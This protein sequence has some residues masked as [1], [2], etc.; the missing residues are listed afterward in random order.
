MATNEDYIDPLDDEENDDTESGESGSEN[1]EETQKTD[2]VKVAED[3]SVDVSDSGE[4][5]EDRKKI[6]EARRQERHDRKTRS[7]EKDDRLRRELSSEREAR[8]ELENR[9]AVIERKS[10]GSELAQLDGTIKQTQNAYAYHKQQLEQAYKDGN[11]AM[12]AE[13]T[14]KMM[15][16]KQRIDDLGR[17]KTAY[18]TQAQAAPPLDRRLVDHADGFM[19]KHNWYKHEGRD[20]DSLMVRTLDNALAQEGWDPKTE[21]YWAELQERVK[22]YLPH[23]TG[24]AT[25]T[26]TDNPRPKAVVSGSGGEAGASGNKG[27]FTLSAARVQALKDAGMWDN[28]TERADAVKRYKAHDQQNKNGR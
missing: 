5:D 20:T 28:P 2:E 13:A 14:E 10:S 22:K 26:A 27:T 16:A 1:T 11:G 3:G 4:V 24:R 8:R 6:Q 9:L 19:K 7:K 25:V 21:E 12:A 17:I 18:T 23:R 15:V